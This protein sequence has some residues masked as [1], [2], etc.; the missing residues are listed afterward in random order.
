MTGLVAVYFTK[1]TSSKCHALEQVAA[2]RHVSA[3]L[4]YVTLK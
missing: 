4:L 3:I 1:S 2:G